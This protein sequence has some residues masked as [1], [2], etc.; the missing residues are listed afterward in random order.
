MTDRRQETSN[1]HGVPGEIAV[2]NMTND[3]DCPVVL[4]STSPEQDELPPSKASKKMIAETAVN[5]NITSAL[6]VSSS[7]KHNRVFINIP[8]EE[9][10]EC[11]SD[12]EANQRSHNRQGVSLSSSQT[13]P[14]H[15]SELQ[16]ST[17]KMAT[18][19][20]L[21]TSRIS[22]KNE[23]M[24][25]KILNQT[26]II[27]IAFLICWTPYVFIALWYQIDIDSASKLPSGLIDFL[28]MF[29]VTN[30]VVNPFIYGK[31]LF[32]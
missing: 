22:V 1:G 30:S 20:S 7:N 24:K 13:S 10:A 27:I 15:P 31:F 8:I 2:M 12:I 25:Q 3:E 23:K 6:L 29:A 11:P 21:S 18:I 19:P 28:Y 16:D 17:I 26:L 14:S 4:K 5:G 9:S 32:R